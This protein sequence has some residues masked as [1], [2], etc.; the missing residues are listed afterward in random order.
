MKRKSTIAWIIKIVLISVAASMV[1]MLISTEVLGRAGLMMAFVM[2][3]VFILIGI[4]F[5]IIAIAVTVASETP[6]HSMA[7]RRERGA[8][9]SLKLVKNATKV[10]SICGD[11]VG[12]VI[13]IVSGTTA[14]LVAA[15]LMMNLGNDFMILELL[16]IGTV[17]GL[18]IGGKALGK[19]VAIKKSTT[20]VHNVGKLI[21]YL[22]IKK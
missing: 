19:I 1:F 9:E 6:F 13:G 21:S 8:T 11:V 18:T 12:D 5:D 2:L 14:G 3:A 17:T 10:N 7:A 22:K 15:S 4:T 16:I 20:I